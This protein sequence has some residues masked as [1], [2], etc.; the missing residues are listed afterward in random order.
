MVAQ[1]PLRIV[2][3]RVDCQKRAKDEEKGE[4]PGAC[5]SGWDLNS[6]VGN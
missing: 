3:S 1:R 4:V 2:E 5:K 6:R